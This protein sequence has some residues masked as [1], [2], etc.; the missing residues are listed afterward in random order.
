MLHVIDEQLLLSMER[1]T[2]LLSRVGLGSGVSLKDQLS[3]INEEILN[4]KEAAQWAMTRQEEIDDFLAYRTRSRLK[5]TGLSCLHPGDQVWRPK[6]RGRGFVDRDGLFQSALGALPSEFAYVAPEPG[7]VGVGR[8]P[9][10]T[11]VDAFDESC[12]HG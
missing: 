12:G 9:S 11:P 8:G 5:W 6:G 7:C 1:K 4:L 3:K 10:E 2:H